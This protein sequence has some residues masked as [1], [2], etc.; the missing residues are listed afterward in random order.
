S[1][2]RYVA[3][4]NRLPERMAPLPLR[5][6]AEASYLITGGLGSLGLKTACWLAEQGAGNIVLAGRREPREAAQA[7]IEQL[8]SQSK[9]RVD[10][11]KCD[12]S[13]SEDVARLIAEVG[14]RLPPLRG[15]VHAAGLAGQ[16][17][18]VELSADELTEV[19]A[20][21]V[22]GAWWLH[23]YTR[24]IKLDFFVGF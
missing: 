22:Q 11:W 24:E 7:T 20:A 19:L 23:E 4:L 8:R 16:R 5:L 3:R 9:C 2:Q 10:V 14:D 15:V 13:R 21:K 17:P 6:H 18:I 12:I 1:G